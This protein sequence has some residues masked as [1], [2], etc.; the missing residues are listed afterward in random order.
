MIDRYVSADSAGGGDGSLERP[1]TLEEG[2]D[3]ALRV[4]VPLIV[5]VKAGKYR[6]P[7]ESQQP[8]RVERF[9]TAG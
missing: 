2:F 1:W 6:L 5:H 3:A 9:S 7:E 4:D 8:I